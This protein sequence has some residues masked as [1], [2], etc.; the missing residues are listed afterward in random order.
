MWE[1]FTDRARLTMCLANQVGLTFRHEYVGTEHLF[2][3]LIM[4]SD[5]VAATALRNL[6][7]N[8]P[9][10]H[11]E[12]ERRFKTGPDNGPRG[13]LPQTP[14]AKAVVEHAIDEARILNHEYVG[15][16]HILLGLLRETED[17]VA[18]VLGNLGLKLEDVRQEV[19]SV[20]MV[21][22]ESEICEPRMYSGVRSQV[23]V[24][25]PKAVSY[26]DL[27]VWRK[28]DEL[29]WQVHALVG[30]FLRGRTPA[31]MSRLSEIALSIP[32]HIAEAYERRG[33]AEKKWFLNIT[34][35]SLRQL[36]YLLEFAQR[37]G[38]LKTEDCQRLDSLADEIGRLLHTLYG[39]LAA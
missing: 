24:K 29:A 37:L 13:K 10:L 34:L 21:G 22:V 17:V 1:R 12:I 38:C 25:K 5:G 20:Y 32:P 28:A 39:S 6:G 4:K 2:L 35:G 11:A 19:L 36:R 30:Q 26:R 3:G 15:T 33:I 23:S 27:P 14:R 16:G 8:L 9:R 31:A 18:Q 7:L